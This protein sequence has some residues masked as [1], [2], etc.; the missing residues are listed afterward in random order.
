MPDDEKEGRK[1]YPSP[2]VNAHNAY[3]ASE[4]WWRR[5]PYVNGTIEVKSLVSRG[6]KNFHF[7]IASRRAAL[8]GNTSLIATFSNLTF[9]LL[10]PWPWP[11]SDDHD[12]RTRARYCERA[13]AHQN[14]VSRSRHS[15]VRARTG[16][17]HR[18]TDAT[19]RITMPHSWA[20]ISRCISC[21]DYAK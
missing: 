11:W 14:Q 8:S 13:S 12:I 3:S 10:W 20:V 2:S 5:I 16:Q 15:K 19:E 1:F 17:T 7:A 9:L 18:Q 6:P 4:I 21:L